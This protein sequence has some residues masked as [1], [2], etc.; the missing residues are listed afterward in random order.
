[1]YESNRYTRS[2]WPIAAALLQFPG[3]LADGTS[4]QD[5]SAD[6]W[7]DTL[8]Q[9][10]DVGFDCVDLTDS[11]LKPANLSTGRL[12]EFRDTL[13]EA[14]L[15]APALSIVRTSVI[16]PQSGATNLEYVH[17][18]IEAAAALGTSTLS[19]GLHQ[20]LTEEQR[21][22][23]WF[24]TAKGATDPLDDR[25]AW[26]LAVERFREI[27]RHAAEYE[28][29]VSLEL[30][31]DTF[32]GTADS[33]VNLIEDIGLDNVGLNP[34]IGN[35]VRLHR[36]IEDWQDML[37]KTLPYTNY[38]QVKNYFRDE[39]PETGLVTSAPAPLEL[40]FINYRTAI[41]EALSLGF[42]GVFCCEHYGGDGLGISAGNR[43]YL[44]SLLPEVRT[45]SRT[46]VTAR[47]KQE[48][49]S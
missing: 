43:R 8:L 23:L 25:E 41:R 22:R 32:L 30:Y 40:G 46:A 26:N 17:R 39:N 19:L 5:A 15:S 28:M 29:V 27:G 18:S 7:L 14:G 13:T 45:E 3:T 36:P 20:A 49:A 16:D 33:A 34:D 9:V 2:D 37:R 35:L 24:W 21:K 38:W 4:V 47:T 31:E 12:T 10:R 48:I 6:N 44:Q 42:N 1:M 11:W